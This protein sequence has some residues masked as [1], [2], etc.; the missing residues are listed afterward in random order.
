M[1]AA[2]LAERDEQVTVLEEQ[3]RGVAGLHEQVIFRVFSLP[4]VL[5]QSHK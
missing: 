2:Q 1:H 4:I 3:L 5:L